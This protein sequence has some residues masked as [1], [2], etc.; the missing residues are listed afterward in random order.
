MNISQIFN[1]R[2]QQAF[3]S[4]RSSRQQYLSAV[5]QLASGGELDEESLLALIDELQITESQLAADIEKQQQRNQ[6]AAELQ[7][8]QQATA[9]VQRLSMEQDR[10]TRERDE[11]MAKWSPKMESIAMQLR[12]A[13]QNELLA[14]GA[15]RRLEETIIDVELLDR[16]KILESR[17]RAVHQQLLGLEE[18]IETAQRILNYARSQ[19]EAEKSAIVIEGAHPQTT[20]VREKN[21]KLAIADAQS[22][23]ESAQAEAATV[24]G[25]RDRLKDQLR[26]I[27]REQ[28]EL[29]KQ[30]LIA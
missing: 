12:S 7:L 28:I 19:L 1:R 10:L 17:R 3:D 18:E 29:N 27:D 2:K 13:Q 5:R 14:F 20:A 21:K 11:F 9:D 4:Q 25:Q 15:K 23:L 26:A 16:Q 22:K 8:A 30:K 6:A 24:F